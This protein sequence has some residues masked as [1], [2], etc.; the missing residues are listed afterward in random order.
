MAALKT[1]HSGRAAEQ[2]QKEIRNYTG[3]QNRRFSHSQQHSQVLQRAITHPLGWLPL[4]CL[5]KIF[6]SNNA[7]ECQPLK[8][9][10]QWVILEKSGA[11]RKKNLL[12]C[13]GGAH[14]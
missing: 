5:E 11:N 12:L 1:N 13:G 4:L 7:K 10:C 8:T 9:D 6:W 3:R 2:V 14:T